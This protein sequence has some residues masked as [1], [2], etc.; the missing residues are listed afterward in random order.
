MSSTDDQPQESR[1]ETFLA[2]VEPHEDSR[3][4]GTDTMNIIYLLSC[5]HS[6]NTLH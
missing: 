3:F 1:S 6:E 4:I 5:V 2:G